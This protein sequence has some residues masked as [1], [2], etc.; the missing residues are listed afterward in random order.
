MRLDTNYVR[1]LSYQ[2]VNLKDVE[3]VITQT[4]EDPEDMGC[5]VGFKGDKDLTEDA[6][7]QL[8]G[9]LKIPYAFTKHLRANGRTNV[10]TY[11]Q[12]QLSQSVSPMVILVSNDDNILSVANTDD[13]YYQGKEVITFDTRLK[14]ELESSDAVLKCQSITI[15][16]GTAHYTLFYKDENKEIEDDSGWRYGFLIEI[17][18]LGDTK[19]IIYALVQRLC[20]V[21]TAILPVKTHSYPLEYET[22]FEDR[23]NMVASF[24]KNPPAPIWMTLEN[25]VDKLKKTTASFREVKDA[26]SKLNKLRVDKEDTETPERINQQ[27]YWKVITKEYNIK[28]LPYKPSKTW[29]SRAATPITTFHLLTTVMR[30]AAAAPNTIPYQ[31]RKSLLLHAGSLLLGTPDLDAVHNPPIIDWDRI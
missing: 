20:D 8:C 27:L 7:R 19:P 10:I 6:L 1:Q 26:R 16:N 9:I 3:L 25:A 18:L 12:K 31:V 11:L 24:L 29:Y 28:D 15:D 13:L 4:S 2:E 17:P 14:E 30:E 21:G 23:W 5:G 22:E